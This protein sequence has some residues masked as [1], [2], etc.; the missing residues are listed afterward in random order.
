MT[1][2][3][4]ADWLIPAGLIALSFI[5]IA[6]GTFRM[7]QLGVGAEI[8]PDNARFFA[9]PL[10]VV[11]HIVSSVIF[12]VLGAFQFAPS[13]RRRKPN[14][15]RAA[16]R[17]LIPC[18]LVVALSGLWMTQF[19]PSG[20]D[21]PA[22]F[23]GPFVYAIRLVAG[24]AMALS[25]CLGFG[26]I[27]RRDIPCHRAWMM[28]GYALGL[29]AGTQVLTHLPWYLFPSIRGELA[30]TLFMGAGWAI[31]LAVAEWLISSE[32]RRQLS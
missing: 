30:R 25:I 2:S 14:W 21:P 24:S 19:Y 4:K 20:I 12:C 11:L 22:S 17:M 3:A 7:V 13:F 32:R 15:H 27:R 6:A 26:A 23:D 5:P 8:T 16:G 9:V 31:N 18:G 10:P 1:S 29:G 28:R